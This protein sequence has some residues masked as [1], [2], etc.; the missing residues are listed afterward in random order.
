MPNAWSYVV[1]WPWVKNWNG[2]LYVG[3][4]SYPLYM[5]YRWQDVEKKFELTGKR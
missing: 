2:E 5:K 3:Y 1:W 4:Y